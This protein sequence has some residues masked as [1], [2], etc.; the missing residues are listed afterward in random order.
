MGFND[1]IEFNKGSGQYRVQQVVLRE[2]FIGK[3]L[4]NLTDLE[5]IIN[6]QF[7]SGYELF[8]MNS[9]FTSSQGF[10][11]GDRTLVNLVFKKIR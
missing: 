5:D 8:T 11:G 1:S 4:K 3:G 2:K 9:S 6:Q 10:G 7:K